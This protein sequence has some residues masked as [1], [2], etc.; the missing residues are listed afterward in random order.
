[1]KKSSGVIL[2][3]FFGVAAGSRKTLIQQMSLKKKSRLIFACF[4]KQTHFYID[5]RM[6]PSAFSE[7][8]TNTCELEKG[9]FR[10]SWVSARQT[11]FPDFYL[12]FKRNCK[13]CQRSRWTDR[14][15]EA[16][17]N[18]CVWKRLQYGLPE[19]IKSPVRIPTRMTAQFED[20]GKQ[21]N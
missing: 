14:V 18:R 5:L 12:S 2:I 15:D 1:M 11:Q 13:S 6:L 4:E 21:G 7:I 20:E 19:S 8:L 16:A 3:V 17:G 9:Q 10:S